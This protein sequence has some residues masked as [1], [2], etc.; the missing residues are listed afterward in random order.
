MQEGTALSSGSFIMIVYNF[1]QC[2]H[3]RAAIGLFTA[4]A[5]LIDIG[6]PRRAILS[7]KVFP[8]FFIAKRVAKTNIHMRIIITF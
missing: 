8:D 1:F 6:N 7:F 5:G 3:A 2:F 4:A